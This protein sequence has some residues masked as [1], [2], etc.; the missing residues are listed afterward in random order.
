LFAYLQY[1]F[2]RGAGF[3]IRLLPEE[4]ALW[5]GRQLGR[6]A[7]LLDWEHRKVAIEN[8]RIAFAREKSEQEIHAIAKKTFQNLGMMAMEFLR[9]PKMTG[10]KFMKDVEIEGVENFEKVR[11]NEKGV[12]FLL[13]HFGNWELMG[14]LTQGLGSRV[15]VI[16]KPIKNKWVDRMITE[17]RGTSGIELVTSAKAGRKIIRALSEKRMVGI[18]VDQRAKRSEGVMVD[19][20]GKMAPTTPALAV[21]GMRTGAPVLPLFLFR[22]EKAKYRL[23]IKDPLELVDTGDVKKDVAT[24]TERI[25]H[26]L[27]MMVRQYPDQYFWVHRRWER[28]RSGRRH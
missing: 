23:V 12:L 13:S 2:I 9:L 25:T 11:N 10:E 22:K 20:F 16:A 24:N 6:I 18:L 7:Y 15:M 19:F 1:L 21:L 27:E 5:L 3:L 28:K 14:L 4:M 26:S 17:L 8:L